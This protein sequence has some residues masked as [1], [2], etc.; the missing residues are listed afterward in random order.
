MNLNELE[1]FVATI[2][3]RIISIEHHVS[4]ETG[5]RPNTCER[6]RNTYI[7]CTVYI[8]TAIIPRFVFVFRVRIF[9]MHVRIYEHEYVFTSVVLHFTRSLLAEGKA[10]L[11]F[12]LSLVFYS[13]ERLTWRI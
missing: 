10:P 1:V 7:T 11:L 13:C 12:S 2:C 9:R 8:Y 3:I 6:E 4:Y 5:W